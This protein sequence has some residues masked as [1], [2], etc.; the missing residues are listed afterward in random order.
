[1]VFKVGDFIE[2]DKKAKGLS[3]VRLTLKKQYQ[4]LDI[5]QDGGLTLLTVENDDGVIKPYNSEWFRYATQRR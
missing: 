1:M 5:E 2:P 4:V 3:C